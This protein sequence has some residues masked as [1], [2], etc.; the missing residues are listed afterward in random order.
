MTCGRGSRRPESGESLYG[1]GA[2]SV[3]LEVSTG[4]RSKRTRLGVRGVR[5]SGIS[6]RG[7]WPGWTI[8]SS[9]S[10]EELS[11]RRPRS[12]SFVRSSEFSPPLRTV[13]VLALAIPIVEPLWCLGDTLYTG[14]TRRLRRL[15]FLR[16]HA[17]IPFQGSSPRVFLDFTSSLHEHGASSYLS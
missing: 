6:S 14:L 7:V 13:F 2:P 8:M 10:S 4:G 11:E 9:S 5:G 15:H 17:M 3:R 12:S 1:G 16:L